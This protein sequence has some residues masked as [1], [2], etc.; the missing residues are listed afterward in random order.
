V[1]SGSNGL[2]F[3]TSAATGL[4][5]CTVN[6]AFYCPTSSQNFL[7]TNTGTNGHSTAIN[8]TVANADGLLSVQTNFL[9]SNLGA[10][11]PGIFDFGLPFFFGRN[12]FIAIE[13]ESTPAGP[14]PYTA[15]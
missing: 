5:M 14:G 13:G 15:Y 3:L 6:T 1:D 2:F 12:V 10:P 9:F 8:F 11:N 7:V 4:P